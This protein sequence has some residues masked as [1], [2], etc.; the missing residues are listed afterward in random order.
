MLATLPSEII[1]NILE[2]VFNGDIPSNLWK[3]IKE[4]PPDPRRDR[5]ESNIPFQTI[6]FFREMSLFRPKAL[7]HQSQ[8]FRPTPQ[9]LQSIFGNRGSGGR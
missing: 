6:A 1:S 8:T 5:V 7:H 4:I 2:Y 9:N 3:I